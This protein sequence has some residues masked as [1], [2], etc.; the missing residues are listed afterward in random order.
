MSIVQKASEVLKS[1]GNGAKQHVISSKQFQDNCMSLTHDIICEICSTDERLTL[2]NIITCKNS[3][4]K[5]LLENE[6][7]EYLT[8]SL[9]CNSILGFDLKSDSIETNKNFYA[10][11]L[12]EKYIAA[13]C[14]LVASDQKALPIRIEDISDIASKLISKK[15]EVSL[16]NISGDVQ[17][18][19]PNNNSNN[20]EKIES[21]LLKNVNESLDSNVTDTKEVKD[22]KIKAKNTTNDQNIF[23]HVERP[24]PY[25]ED[26][27]EEILVPEE[28]TEAANPPESTGQFEIKE[29]PT[30]KEE[31]KKIEIPKTDL[32][33]KSSEIRSSKPAEPSQTQTSTPS[34]ST[35][36]KIEQTIEIKNSKEESRSNAPESV[37]LRLSNRIKVL[38]KNMTLSTQYLEELSR[39]YKKQIEDLQQSYSKLQILYDNLNQSKKETDK[40]DVDDKR[41]L[42]EDIQEISQKTDFLEI[43]LIILTSLLILLIIF[44]IVLFKRL[45]IL[46]DAFVMNE[47]RTSSENLVNNNNNIEQHVNQNGIEKTRT[48]SSNGKKKSKRVRKI[49]APNILSQRN[50]INNNNK[51]E[52]AVTQTALSRTVSAPEKVTETIEIKENLPQIEHSTALEENDEILLSAFEDLKI[53]NISKDS[54]DDGPK[55]IEDYDFDTTSTASV[56]T[57]D[58]KTSNGSVNFVR[59]LSSP[60]TFLKLK[61]TTAL[62]IKNGRP[63]VLNDKF[64]LKKAKSESPPNFKSS[65]SNIH[66]IQKS[67]SF[68]DDGLKF[69]KNNSFKKLFKKLF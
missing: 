5:N 13:M 51:A 35:E 29:I 41:R 50:G 67:N 32:S 25:I 28:A 47:C 11:I 31:E 60:T 23:N 18:K 36:V 49:S 24:P 40:K 58:H 33:T 30:Q 42:N 46:R 21:E 14:N 16:K 22:E 37:F 53:D 69:R 27:Q 56:K 17:C 52:F 43:V 26:S 38:E 7:K 12:P 62:K 2:N 34:T 20:A 6:V 55:K 8:N 45:S 59:R 66:I 64:K 1:N 48:T 39:K 57:E 65:T 63:A 44:I 61:K 4:L 9:T 15:D 10:S 54:S 3:A 68:E 19:H